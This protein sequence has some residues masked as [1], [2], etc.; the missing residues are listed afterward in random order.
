MIFQHLCYSDIGYSDIVIYIYICRCIGHSDIA[1]SC[2]LGQVENRFPFQY[3]VSPYGI[4]CVV[5]A[6][7][8][9]HAIKGR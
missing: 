9:Q 8:P 3:K 4:H 1:M 5:I 2:L 6:N 7:H